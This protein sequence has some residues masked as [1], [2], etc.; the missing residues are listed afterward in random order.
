MQILVEANNRKKVDLL[1]ELLR[2]LEFV[3][4]I[5]IADASAPVVSPTVDR[6]FFNRFYGSLKTGST[7]DEIDQK[8]NA[9][10]T[11]WE[12]NTF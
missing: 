3:K 2:S 10:R 8:L 11:E 4:S 12:R 1:V 6:S 7:P 9:L 5:R